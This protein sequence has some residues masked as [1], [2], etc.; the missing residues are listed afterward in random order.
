[1][2]KTIKS[3]KETQKVAGELAH[4]IKR[5]AYP[6]HGAMV[7]ALEGELGAGKTT[8][9]KAFLKSLGLGFG[10]T[11]PTF[12]IMRKYPTSWPKY[13]SVYHMDCYRIK[14]PKELLDLGFGEI[15]GNPENLVLIEWADMVQH[16]IP[17]D[18]IWIKFK[19]GEEE[20]ERTIDIQLRER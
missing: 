17:K 16:L 2:I 13:K 12:I 3:T 8:F 9:V 19:H 10:V 7:V 11:S 15:I 18:A 20:G 1:M 14:H 6:H 4:E 5:D